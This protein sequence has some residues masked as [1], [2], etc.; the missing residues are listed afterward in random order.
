[1]EVTTMRWIACLVF[2]TLIP[3]SSELAN[4]QQD[5]PPFE[6]T[7]CKFDIP[8]G[9]NVDC[10][11]LSVPEDRG[12]S[13]NGLVRTAF[14]PQVQVNIRTIRLF[15]AIFHAKN[16]HPELAPIVFL[17]GGPGVHSLDWTTKT[18]PL[19]FVL[20]LAIEH[21]LIFFDQRGT[22][23]SQPTL[24]CPE[25]TQVD[26]S[27][28]E[29]NSQSRTAGQQSN[30]AL[31]ACH[32]RLVRQGVKLTSY[33]TAASAADVND[34]RQALGY[35]KVN[36]YGVS[37]G[38][39]LAQS[40]MLQFPQT[41]RSVVLDSTLVGLQGFSY[42]GTGP[43]F[44]VLFQGCAKDQA[45]NAS[46]PNLG[47]VFNQLVRQLNQHPVLVS[48]KH[49]FTGQQYKILLTGDDVEMG[50]FWGLYSTV[51]IPTLPSLIFDARDGDYGGLA[52]LAFENEIVLSDENISTGMNIAVNCIDQFS[53][54]LCR[55]WLGDLPRPTSPRTVTSSLP[56]L[57]LGG[58]YDPVTPPQYSQT[59]T[60][61][62][63]N[64][65]FLEFPGTGHEAAFSGQCPMDIVLA[66]YKAPDQQPD[67]TCIS[68]LHEPDFVLRL[69]ETF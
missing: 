29:K 3:G 4:A 65:V 12:Q 20:Q 56:T 50:L 27:N 1:M 49:R 51:R 62:L 23:Y 38:T 22:G 15:V 10:G 2:V 19:N 32:D 39:R 63:K 55:Q 14:E 18:R 54:G 68:K 34:L 6:K 40:V 46:Y 35:E 13:S 53:R 66:F 36:L 42:R 45:C 67:A 41:V 69:V 8:P 28:L 60:R 57:V 5:P 48:V 11:Y 21:D 30:A 26:Y 61:T 31:S 33:S 37:Y 9:Q 7:A 59:V 17:D 52:E 64:S 25:I 44:D 43:A 16:P 58:E 47:A 24:D